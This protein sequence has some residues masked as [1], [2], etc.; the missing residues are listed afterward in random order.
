MIL[1]KIVFLA[2]TLLIYGLF[3]YILNKSLER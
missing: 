3:I 1:E 2:L